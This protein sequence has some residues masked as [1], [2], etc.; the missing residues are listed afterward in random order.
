MRRILAKTY[1]LG[2]KC[3]E[4]FT[5]WLL[6]EWLS[7]S[8]GRHLY[9]L[10]GAI[11]VATCF[12]FTVHVTGPGTVQVEDELDV[13]AQKGELVLL[14][15]LVRADLF[16][17]GQEAVHLVHC[18]LLRWGLGPIGVL[19]C[20]SCTAGLLPKFLH[21]GSAI[22]LFS[23][24]VPRWNIVLN[25]YF[26]VIL[27]MTAL[28]TGFSLSTAT[29]LALVTGYWPGSGLGG[30]LVFA[31]SFAA[32]W[33][34]SMLVGALSRSSAAVLV[35]NVLLWLVSYAVNVSHLCQTSYP[36]EHITAS[37]LARLPYWCLPKPA[38]LLILLSDLIGAGQHFASFPELLDSGNVAEFNPWWS[39][40]SSLGFGLIM[41]V[42]AGWELRRAETEVFS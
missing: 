29:S 6:D 17:G 42:L 2:C 20:L 21:S 14:F 7:L 28:A 16:R 22:L 35:A 41:A 18:W 25:K 3:V 38:D 9:V 33:G 27:I 30:V 11:L 36:S 39:V 4:S 10:L 34:F 26:A 13:P 24:P 12:C 1:R 23:S 32:F 15:G 37:V 40:G 31:V 19:L 5:Y 8:A